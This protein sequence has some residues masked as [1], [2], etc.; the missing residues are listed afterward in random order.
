MASTLT[1]L[2]LRYALWS[3]RNLFTAICATGFGLIV[4]LALLAPWLG[5][6]DPAGI[7][8]ASKQ[9]GRAHV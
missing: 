8:F 5:L 1:S 3:R 9:I 2:F 7:D 6:T 4:L